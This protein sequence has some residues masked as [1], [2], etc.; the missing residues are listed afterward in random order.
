M[1]RRPLRQR[2]ALPR[3]RSPL[4]LL[5]PIALLIALVAAGC[6]DSV[7][8][9]AVAN[10]DGD[11]IK[12][13][14]FDHWLN[15]AARSQSAQP[16][17]S[18]S[19]VVV[20]DPPQFT[21]CIAART[22][23]QGKDAPKLNAQQARQ[24][25][26][27]EYDLL[28]DQVMQFLISS[29][30]VE[31]EAEEQGVEATPEEVNRTFDEQKRQSFPSDKEY[32]AFLKASGQTEED[33]K[34]RV[35]LDVLS[36]EVRKKIVG[37]E[38][39]SVSDKEVRDFYNKNRSQFG[40]PERRELSVVLTEKESD[41]TKA[42]QALDDGQS[43]KQVAERYSIDE[44]SKDKGGK[45]T[46]TK[47]QQEKALD[48][49]VFKARQGQIVGPVK[50]QFGYYV[51][52][53]DKT[54]P[55]SQQSFEQARETIKAQLRSEK[56]QKALDKFVKEFEKEY[57]EKTNCAKGFTIYQCKNGPKQPPQQPGVPGAAGGAP[58][59]AEGGGAPPGAAGGG[60]GSQGGSV[61]QGGAPEG[62]GSSGR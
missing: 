40:Q 44:A 25:C 14:Q 43:F 54:T 22:K 49:A 26:Q 37:G 60:S 15:A 4:R 48:D 2:L 1:S 58:P 13:S 17:A 23:P 3:R 57:R 52:R 51:F 41:A 7:P 61:P 21:K 31:L 24:F 35:K 50:T 46:M 53:V 10:V 47:G 32:Q 36:N 20:P 12:K 6:G 45:L 56:E 16:G 62:G 29:H 38:N 9:D 27:Q 19:D 34:Y 30:W 33:L 11:I 39:S 5:A 42:K 59:G 55:A 18:P 8:K 28:K